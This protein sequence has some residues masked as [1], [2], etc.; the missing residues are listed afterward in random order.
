[1]SLNEKGLITC[2]KCGE[3]TGNDWTQCGG[4]CPMPGSPH[5]NSSASP[6]A[7]KDV[8]GIVGKLTKIADA[9]RRNDG[10][11]IPLGEQVREAASAITR[12]AA[13][14]DEARAEVATA[15]RERDALA[16]FHTDDRTALI[17]KAEAFKARTETAEAEA[18]TLRKELERAKAVIAPF[19][20]FGADNTDD[21]G[22]GGNRCEGERI[23]DWFGP[24]DFRAAREWLEGK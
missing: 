23:R 10:T 11:D 12:L 22:W 24:S 16:A 3:V 8:V 6:E 17:V 1:M 14:R 19:A 18:A 9:S 4:S 7:P 5:Y 2:P 13:E 20:Q 21:E 15:R